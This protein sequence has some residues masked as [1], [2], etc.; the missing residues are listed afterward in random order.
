MSLIVQKYGGAVLSDISKIRSVA[1]L[2]ADLQAAGNQLVV[3][4]SAMGHTTDDLVRLANSVSRKP[5]RR[6]MDMLL[7]V[8]ERITMSLLAMAI[9]DTG[10]AKAVSYTGSQ[11][12]IITDN[13]HSDARI[14]AVR[15]DRINRALEAG[16][17]VVVAGFQGVS[18]EKEITTLGRGGSDT[19]ALALA[20]ALG[21]D[22]CDLIKEVPG[23]FTGDPT[24]IP[25]AL[26][27]PEMD[28]ASARGI[29]LG[30][31]RILKHQCIELAER[32]GIE[33][34]VGEPENH[35]IIRRRTD[36]PFFSLAL[37]ENLVLY[38]GEKP[39]DL[40][41]FSLDDEVMV[42]NDK[43]IL[44]SDDSSLVSSIDRSDFEIITGLSKITAVG[45]GVMNLP[46]WMAK[47]EGVKRIEYCSI[48]GNEA[49]IVFA[50]SEP[51]AVLRR[52]HTRISEN[53]SGV[54]EK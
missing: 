47:D 44:C 52:M 13:R 35:T 10:R 45:E 28:Y 46:N 50:S 30:G 6:E 2:I 43:M 15:G 11:V 14:V 32:Y 51:K 17:V 3:V 41:G 53:S 20:A 9:E 34:R 27:I 5:P 4:V 39:D 25:E 22:R 18:F 26:P 48:Q 37:K 23:V 19:T 31:A 7:S 12:G 54:T 24:V 42:V 8:G 21:A 1:A 40:D 38:K 29:S 36:E 33:I 16:L 49:K